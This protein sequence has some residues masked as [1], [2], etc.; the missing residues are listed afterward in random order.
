DERAAW[1]PRVVRAHRGRVRDRRGV[2]MLRAALG[3][4]A[5]AV[6][7]AIVF[8]VALAAGVLIHVGLPPM[9]RVVATEVTRA[10]A[11]LF[12]GRIVIDHV[13]GLTLTGV[14]GVRAHV[15]DADGHRVI[16][17]DLAEARIDTIGLVRSLT[18]GGAIAIDIPVARI[19]AADVTLDGDSSGAIA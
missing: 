9:R 1:A 18:S 14:T 19:D 16:A 7:L 17:V 15:D 8:V 13:D 2:L 3:H 6:G 11:P 4:L 5:G 10:L 12:V